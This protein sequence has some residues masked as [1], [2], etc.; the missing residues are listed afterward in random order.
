MKSRML[1]SACALGLTLVS[2]IAWADDPR[3]PVMRDPRARA[4]DRA[5]I[6]QLNLRE[7]ARV[8]AR[9]AALAKQWRA[10][11]QWQEQRNRGD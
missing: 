2:S 6:R 10:W 7:L 5:V 3:D 11:R 1:V 9:D 4:H 8:R